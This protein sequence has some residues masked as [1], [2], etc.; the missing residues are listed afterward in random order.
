M[1]PGELRRWNVPD[2]NG[3]HDYFLV[4]S[5]QSWASDGSMGAGDVTFLTNGRVVTDDINY[6]GA[7][8]EAV[9]ESR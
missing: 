7:I 4:I 1:K 6:I 8:S 3:G 2:L 5:I 9:H